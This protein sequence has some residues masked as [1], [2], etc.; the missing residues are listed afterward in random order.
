[1]SPTIYTA[2]IKQFWTS[3]KVKIVNEDVRLQTLVDGKKVV[4]NEASIIRD[5]RLDDAEG[6]CFSWAIT[7]L[8][9]TMMVQAPKEVGEIPIDTQDTPILTQP[10][11][12]QPQT[13]HK[14]RRKQRKEIEVSHDEPPTEEHIPTPSHDPLASAG[15]N[16]EQDATVAKKDVSIAVDKVVTTVDDVEIT[17]AATTPQTS[18]DDAKDKGK[19]IMVEPEKPL[20]KKDQ[21]VTNEEISRKLEAQMKAKIEEEERIAREKVEANIAV[22]E[23]WDEVQAMIDAN[24]ELS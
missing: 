22:I 18:K 3:A 4:L 10:S 2:C 17:T 15:E 14:L 19:E 24:M 7:P 21:I 11:S 6:T 20:K 23:K 9:E 5:L 16:V 8:F 12:S 1:M 13:K